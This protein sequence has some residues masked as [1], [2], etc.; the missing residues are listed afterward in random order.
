MAYNSN[1]IIGQVVWL[2]I[3]ITLLDRSY[4]YNSNYMHCAGR[5]AYNSN[6]IIG[7][8]VWLI[9]VITCIVQVVWLIIVITYIGQVV[10][11][12]AAPGG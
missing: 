9:I 2:I 10:W 8:V 12:T 6:Y 7:Q 11:L 1:Y 4:G 3:E 5:M